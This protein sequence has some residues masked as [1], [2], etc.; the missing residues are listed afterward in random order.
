MAAA[1]NLNE[2]IQFSLEKCR[3]QVRREQLKTLH[4]VFQNAATV[5]PQFVALQMR[6]FNI[7]ARLVRRAFTKKELPRALRLYRE[8][9]SAGIVKMVM[10]M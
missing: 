3:S 9:L 6:F 1:A 2:H 10:Q 7:D 5:P 4:S 8:Y